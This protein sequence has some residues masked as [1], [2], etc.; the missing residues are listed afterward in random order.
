MEREGTR[1]LESFKLGTLSRTHEATL[2][3][4][5]DEENLK[6]VCEEEFQK[7]N[8]IFALDIIHNLKFLVDTG[9]RISIIRRDCIPLGISEV[10]EDR[11]REFMG[12]SGGAVKFHTHVE[13]PLKLTDF[14]N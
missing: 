13:L 9:S 5:P 10:K 14:R 3:P 7:D 1:E 4:K 11:L 6:W 12:I 8:P 2:R